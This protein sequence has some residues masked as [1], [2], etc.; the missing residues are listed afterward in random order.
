MIRDAGRQVGRAHRAGDQH[1]ALRQQIGDLRHR[2]GFAGQEERKRRFRPDQDVG[3][4]HAGRLRPGRA[5][6][7]RQIFL[8]H[9]RLGGVVEFDVLLQVGL[10]D[11][12][13]DAWRPSRSAAA[14]GG[15]RRRC[16]SRR[17]APAPRPARSTACGRAS[18]PSI[19]T[20]GL[21]KIAT[22]QER[23]A[24][25]ADQRR[26]LRQRQRLGQRVAERIPRKAGQH[27]A[28][29]PFANGQAGGEREHARGIAGPDQPRQ[30][31]AE[32]GEQREIGGQAQHRERHQPGE[33]RRIDQEGVAD[34]VQ[35]RHE[36][37]EPEPEAGHR[38]R[39]HAA[40]ASGAR[41]VDQPD[42]RPER[43]GTAPARH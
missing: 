8:H 24:P 43:S 41:A 25:Q 30:R 4:A 26:R 36:I 37:A 22:R 39:R 5:V 34:P 42:Q 3:V 7:Q 13:L 19:S 35:S 40:P 1:R 29:Q 31:K 21:A 17:A 18:V 32:R 12:Q 2:I 20:A 10:H 33:G 38:R 11:P 23:H 6:G 9:L 14:T 15:R 27:M 28:A 16:P